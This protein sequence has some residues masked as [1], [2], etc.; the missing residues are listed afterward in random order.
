MTWIGTN[1]TNVVVSQGGAA[2]LM[3]AI[4]S[5]L[6]EAGWRL[7]S[8]GGGA[9]SGTYQA[10]NA[11]GVT[12]VSDALTTA[13]SLN[14]NGAWFRI[15][16]P[17]ST[18]AGREYVFQRGDG[19]TKM[20]I[21]Y[22][23]ASGFTGSD[24]TYAVGEQY[25]P[26][27]NGGDEVSLFTSISDSGVQASNSLDTTYST[28]RVHCVASS[29]VSPGG[30]WEF[31]ALSTNGTSDPIIIYQAGLLPGTYDSNDGDPS[32]RGVGKTKYF[33]QIYSSAQSGAGTGANSYIVDSRDIASFWYAYGTDE[34][35]Y[36]DYARLGQYITALRPAW[37]TYNTNLNSIYDDKPSLL[38]G[39]TV[40]ATSHSSSTKSRVVKGFTNEFKTFTGNHALGDTFNLDSE[41]PY[42]TI[43]TFYIGIAMPWVRNVTPEF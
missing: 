21:K 3:W 15:K 24:A 37:G 26:S 2:D 16:E 42:I 19:G 4:K 22:S 8:F 14:V 13:A 23:R 41:S 30:V 7:M 10:P 32:Y 35:V 43:N 39:G 9:S 33:V 27:T 6:L 28:G 18:T 29:T 12:A 20:N 34:E 1:S 11:D 5:A 25:S 31:Y 36:V 40:N 38:P 17:G